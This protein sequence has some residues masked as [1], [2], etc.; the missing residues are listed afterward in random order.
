M[1]V[2]VPAAGPSP[3]GGVGP[4]CVGEPGSSGALTSLELAGNVVGEPGSELALPIATAT[5]LEP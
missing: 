4:G 3:L 5:P 1:G 2:S